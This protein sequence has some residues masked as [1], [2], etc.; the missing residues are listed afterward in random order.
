MKTVIVLVVCKHCEHEEVV[1][2]QVTQDEIRWQCS[3]CDRL[4]E[5]PYE[6]ERW[7]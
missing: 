3:K 6:P 1:D 5:K 2:A 4:N 7:E